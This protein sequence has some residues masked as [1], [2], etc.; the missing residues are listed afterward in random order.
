MSSS[1]SSQQ[2]LGTVEFALPRLQLRAHFAQFPLESERTASGLL[3]A[4]YGVAVVAD[5]IGKKEID[6]RILQGQAL[7]GRA[8]LGEKAARE[9]GKQFGGRVRQA[10]GEP[11][12]AAQTADDSRSPDRA[13]AR[14]AEPWRVRVLLGVDQER[15]AAIHVAAHQIDAQICLAPVLD[16][17]VFE[18]F[19]QKLFGRLFVSGVDFDEI[20][21]HADRVQICAWPRSMAVNSR[22]T[23]SVV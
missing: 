21:Q 19:V 1:R 10:V 14:L 12:N 22:F 11:Q 4:T 9:A 5:A 16:Y 15:R 7:R 20:G 17:Y 23:D 8:I 18:L 6:V 13:P 3:S 2:R